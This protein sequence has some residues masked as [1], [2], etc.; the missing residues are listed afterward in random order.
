MVVTIAVPLRAAFGLQ[1]FITAR[2]LDN[3]AKVMLATGMVVGYGYLME[4]FTAWY[5]HNP[6]EQY[7]TLRNRPFGPYAHT[8]WMMIGCNVLIPQAFWVPWV[9][10]NPVLLWILA[11]FVNIGMWLERYVIVITS[12]HR[13][14]LPSAWSMYHGTFWD[15]ATYYGTLGLFLSL[16]FLFIRFLPVISI[17]EMRELVH[18]TQE[19]QAEPGAPEGAAS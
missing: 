7:M 8:Y 10:N 3:M 18:E 16:M 9:R 5:S 13:D 4:T 11:I 14:F 2:H 12:L 19:V 15:Y 17:A 6:F 1:D